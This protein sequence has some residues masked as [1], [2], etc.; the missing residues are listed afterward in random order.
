MQHTNIY[1][2]I[3]CIISNDFRL[4]INSAANQYWI[5]IQLNVRMFDVTLNQC[6]FNVVFLLGRTKKLQD[7]AY[8]QPLNCVMTYQQLLWCMM[9]KFNSTWLIEMN[10]TKPCLVSLYRHQWVPEQQWE[11]WP[12]LREH[13]RL[14]HLPVWGW[15]WTQ[16]RWTHLWWYEVQ[17]YKKFNDFKV[18]FA[19]W[20][21][22]P[23]DV[24]V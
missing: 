18:N 6:Y 5:S 2:T 14:L 22:L 17:I 8:Q 11:L 1:Q 9:Q 15:L 23:S 19:K 24:I 7:V 13:C 4:H 10:H 12:L 21:F 20:F 3:G 16:C